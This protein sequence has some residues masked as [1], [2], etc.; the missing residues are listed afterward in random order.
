MLGARAPKKLRKTCAKVR[1]RGRWHARSG[2]NPPPSFRR[3]LCGVLNRMFKNPKVFLNTISSSKTKFYRAR[4][5]H[6][7]NLAGAPGAHFFVFLTLISIIFRCYV[8]S[9]FEVAFRT[10]FFRCLINF[11]RFGE[12]FRRVSGRC[13]RCLF[14][15]ISKNA[16]L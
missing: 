4:A 2:E 12:G 6:R 8:A 5:W 9:S 3:R 15:L 1:S 11:L 7:P 10:N 14:A 16:I 13:F